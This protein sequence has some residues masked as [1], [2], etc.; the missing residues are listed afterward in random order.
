[1]YYYLSFWQK[2]SDNIAHLLLPIFCVTYGALAFMTRQ[3]RN[4]MIDTFQQDY[5]RTARAKGL[6]EHTIVWRHGFRNSIFPLITLFGNVLPRAFAGSVVIEV[7]FN[8]QGM[9]YLMWDSWQ[10][11]YTVLMITALLTVIGI[12]LA[13]LLY[14]FIDPRIQFGRK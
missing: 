6:S 10:V 11:V 1:L 3:L 8:I 14:A 7:I 2:L 4:S 5:I 9:G 12:L 13:D